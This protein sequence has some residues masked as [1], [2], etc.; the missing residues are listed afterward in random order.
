MLNKEQLEN[1]FSS[2]LEEIHPKKLIKKQCKFENDKFYVNS[3][4]FEI[5]KNKKIHIFG[6]GK[7]VLSMAEALYEIMEEKI[8][9][10]LLVGAYEN[11]FKKQ[12]LTYI[13]STHP[14]P[15]Q[16]S[17]KGAKAL[18]KEFESLDE[19]DFFIYLLSGGNSALVELPA[20]EIS[21]EEFQETTKLMLENSMPIE[22]INCVRKH[23]SQVKGGR[24]ARFTK[25]KGVVLTLSDVLGDNL[26]AIGSAPLY[27][28]STTFQDAFDDLKKYNIFEKVPN[29]VQN[30]LQKAIKSKDLETPKSESSNIKHYLIGSNDILLNE[31]KNILE[32]KNLNPIIVDEKIDDDVELVCKNLLQFCKEKKEGCFIFGGE[33]TVNVSGNGKGGRNQHLVLSFL[34][35]YPKDENIIFLSGASDGIDG[36]SDACGAI[37][38]KDTVKKVQELNLDIKKYMED[39]DSN[40]FFDKLNQLLKPGPTHNNMLDIVIILKN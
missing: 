32:K 33:A 31:A 10:A 1:I 17:V 8:D 37:I 12:N 7:A 18:I 36:N 19:D 3:E 11:N 20:D 21:L 34:N 40:N 4:S 29:S 14:L 30:Y 22:S 23:I 38:D 15:S 9:K 16:K 24:L 6:S 26:E 5:P 25:A 27:F 28:D 39:F 2:I 13:K 35:S